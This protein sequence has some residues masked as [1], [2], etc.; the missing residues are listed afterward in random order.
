MASDDRPASGTA[1]P[2]APR[3]FYGWIILAA[4]VGILAV[5]YVA[6][7]SYALFLV[8]LVREFGWTRAEAGGAFSVYVLFHALCSPIVGR[9]VDRFGPRPLV[10]VGALLVGAGLLGCSQLT[11]LW[12]LYL[13]FGVLSAIG[14]TVMGWVPCITLVGR[15]FSRRLGLAVGIAGAGIGVGTFL[16]APPIQFLIDGYGWRT[17]Y[18]VLAATLAVLPQPLALLLRARPEEMGLTRD[19]APA[20]RGDGRETKAA[21]PS[22]AGP[23]G[24]SPTDPRVVDP[25][26]VRQEWTVARALRTRRFYLIWATFGLISFAVQQ[27]H[28]HEVAYLVGNG[29]DPILAAAVVGAVGL[30]SIF[31]KIVV[32]TGSDYLGREQMLTIGLGGGIAA[33]LLLVSFAGG[34]SPAPL[35]FLFAGLFALGYS[36]TAPLSP[37]IASDLFYGRHYG[38]IYGLLNVSGGVGGATGAW[39]AGYV[40][41]QTGSYQAAW[42]LA[43][44]AFAA[45][46]ALGWIVAPRKVLRTPGQARRYLAARAAEAPPASRPSRVES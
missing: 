41:D 46:I 33:E 19:G 36:V 5:A 11:E 17:T 16:A 18:L 31:G 23:R 6:W 37:A 27:T 14:V 35:L 7:Y 25:V 45:A 15:W 44:A 39:L 38:S 40:Y 13:C 30:V 42:L 9:L 8:A 1:R 43:A 4:V 21:R 20:R 3:L 34:G 2:P 24:A 28:A 10:Q 29:Y 32:G 12:Q 22:A 26:W